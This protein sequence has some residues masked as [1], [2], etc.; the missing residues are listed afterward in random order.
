MVTKKQEHTT[1]YWAL[2]CF[3]QLK[4]SHE[5]PS[6]KGKTEKVK[7]KEFDNREVYRWIVFD[8]DGFNLCYPLNKLEY[9]AYKN[10]ERELWRC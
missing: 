3:K 10:L 2:E 8:H 7:I 5:S 6:F 9:E 4:L 1:T